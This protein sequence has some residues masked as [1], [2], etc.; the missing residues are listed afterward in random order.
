MQCQH[1]KCKNPILNAEK[2]WNRDARVNPFLS[3]FQIALNNFLFNQGLLD[4]ESDTL[5][6]ES[7]FLSCWFKIH[8]N[9]CNIFHFFCLGKFIFIKNIN[10]SKNKLKSKKSFWQFTLSSVNGYCGLWW[11]LYWQRDW[12][13]LIHF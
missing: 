2:L 9:S 10:H 4:N 1:L 6:S 11:L 13:P 3:D 8:V 7:L 5:T 12:N